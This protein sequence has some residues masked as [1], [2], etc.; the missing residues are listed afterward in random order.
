MIPSK[1]TLQAMIPLI[2]PGKRL[3]DAMASH[4]RKNEKNAPKQPQPKS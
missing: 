2:V 3:V 1:L 4:N